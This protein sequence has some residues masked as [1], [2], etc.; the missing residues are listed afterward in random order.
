MA[1][2]KEINLK[3]KDERRNK[4]LTAS[5]SLFASRGLSGTKI[6][7][8]SKKAEMS[9]GLI[10][11]YYSSKEEIYIELIRTA[12]YKLI[13]STQVLED[14]D[15]RPKEKIK[16]AI[17]EI[18]KSIGISK[19]HALNHLLI[20][21]AMVFENVPDDIKSLLENE[22]KKPYEI[23]ARIMKEGQRRRRI[24]KYDVDDM[25]LIFWSTI[26]GLALNKVAYGDEFKAPNTDI[27]ISMF[28]R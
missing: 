8:I 27:I 15:I 14:L 23:I 6:I 5:L 4:I 25:S 10:Y 21:Q 17:N 3:L 1:R 16:L 18:V 9:Q 22:T 20:T 13:K 24:K 7:D 11:H 19:A 2:T 12:V 28:V 26:K